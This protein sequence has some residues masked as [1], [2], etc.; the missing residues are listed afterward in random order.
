MATSRLIGLCMG[1]GAAVALA[2]SVSVAALD[3]TDMFSFVPSYRAVWYEL[4]VR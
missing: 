4:D 1:L 3:E 2:D